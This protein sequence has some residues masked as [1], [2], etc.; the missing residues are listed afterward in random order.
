MRRDGTSIERTGGRDPHAQLV[1]ASLFELVGHDLLGGGGRGDGIIDLGGRHDA[2]VAAE[3]A[4]LHPPVDALE[5]P[6]IHAAA[7]TR[8]HRARE[9]SYVEAEK[10]RPRVGVRGDQ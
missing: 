3:R 5:D 4:V 9:V 10:A 1:S 7:R 8:R 2:P 6:P